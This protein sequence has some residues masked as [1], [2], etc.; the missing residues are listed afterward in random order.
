[1]V[2]LSDNTDPQ[3]QGRSDEVGVPRLSLCMSI[4]QNED[5]FAD[6]HFGARCFGFVFL[7]RHALFCGCLLCSLCFLSVSAWPVW[8]LFDLV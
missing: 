6:R 2:A 5:G 7:I 1:M 4:S 3:E 8:S